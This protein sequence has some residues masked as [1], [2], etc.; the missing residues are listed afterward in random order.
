MNP[1]HPDDIQVPHDNTPTPPDAMDASLV[2]AAITLETAR[3]FIAWTDRRHQTPRQAQYA[4]GVTRDDILIGVLMAGETDSEPSDTL[5]VFLL[6]TQD[7]HDAT[8]IAL[9]RGAWQHARAR[10]YRRLIIRAARSL[11]LTEAGL[12]PSPAH[13]NYG[14]ERQDHTDTVLWTVTAPREGG[15]QR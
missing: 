9:L 1:S 11:D 14:Q 3:A 8:R 15:E 6:S 4:L 5:E 10:G 7:A 2:V 13:Q 12:R